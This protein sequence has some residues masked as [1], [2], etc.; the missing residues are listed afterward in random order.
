MKRKIP[1]IPIPA[2][3]KYKELYLFSRIPSEPNTKDSS[4]FMD[5]RSETYHSVSFDTTHLFSATSNSISISIVPSVDSFNIDSPSKKKYEKFGKAK[6]LQFSKQRKSVYSK[7]FPQNSIPVQITLK[8]DRQPLPSAPIYTYNQKYKIHILD[9]S[10]SALESSEPPEIS[11]PHGC[12]T[13][14][15]PASFTRKPELKFSPDLTARYPT[16]RS[17]PRLS[18]RRSKRN[19]NMQFEMNKAWCETFT[20]DLDDVGFIYKSETEK[21]I[22]A[23][24]EHIP[25]D[26]IEEATRTAREELTDTVEFFDA[27]EEKLPNN[28]ETLNNNNNANINA[29][30]NTSSDQFYNLPPPES[31]KSP[32]RTS[33]KVRQKKMTASELNKEWQFSDPKIA[34]M[35]IQAMTKSGEGPPKK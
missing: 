35:I 7:Y 24:S 11:N 5:S 30:I 28:Y 10:S 31:S 17:S 22:P 13:L 4:T 3:D 26:F 34:K 15:N 9:Q 12:N 25:D 1:E 8:Y 19:D 20:L 14:G 16:S 21:P 6:F 18:N 32:K 27:F 29:N 33:P 23:S 2:S